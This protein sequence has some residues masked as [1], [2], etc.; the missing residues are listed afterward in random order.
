MA[1]TPQTMVL[2]SLLLSLS[3]LPIAL[4]LAEAGAESEDTAA[5]LAF[6]AAAVGSSSGTSGAV[7]A[8]WNGSGAGPCTWDGVKCSRIGRVVALRLRSLGLSGTLS[9]AVGNLSSLRELDLSSNWLRGEI[10][11]SLGRLRRLRTL[12]LS[13]NTLS[14]AVPGNLTACT[15]LRYLNLGSN[16][17]SGHVPAGLGGALARLEVLWLTNN[18][19]TGALPASL[20]N[21]TS[22]RQLGLGLNALDGPI[23]PEL[24]RNMARLEYV[25]LCHNHLRG[26]IP[27]P[28]YNVSSLA[29]LDVGQNALHG[30]IP[31]GIHVQLPRLRYLA[32]FE[33]HFSGAIPPTISNLTQLVELELSENRFSGL[34]PR[35]LG[36]LQD[37][38]KLLLDDNML[39]AGDKM[40]GWEFMESLANCSKLNLFGLGGNDFTGDLPASVA[41]LS[42]TLEWLYLE[43]L[44]ISG[45]IPSEIGNLVGLK[46]LVLTDTDISGAIPD[47]IGRMENL[48]E[49]HLDNNSLSGPVP[50][51]VGNLTKLM[52]LSAS[53]NSLGGSI[54]R[55]LGKL[56]DLT[57][58]DLSSNHLNGSIPEE[59]FQ[60]QSLSLL[61]DLS[62]N[63][64]SGP[65]PPNVGRLANLNTLRLSGNQL[66]GQLPAGIRD[67]V[68]L[69]ELLLDSNSF[70]GSI[71]EALGDIKGLRV[72]NLTM[73][74]FSGAIP[75]ALGSI[76]SMQQLYVARNSL[77]GP[78]PADLQN[79]TSLSDLDLSFND[80]QGEVPDR[81]FFRNLPRSS[82]AGNENLCGGMPRLRLHPCPTSASG[83]NSRSKRWPPLKHVE[84]ALA[85]VGA[86]VFLASLLA[87]A[88]QL[89]VC[90]SRKQR[91]QQ[92]KRQPLGA[93]A[94]TGERY[95][96]VSYK[97]LS[98][99]TKGF[100]D[101][102]LLGRGSY[103]T[104]YR[105]VLSRLTDDGGR[106]VAAS[107]AAVAVKVFD[108][109]RSG[110][111]RSFVA[112][113][114]ALRS[115]R[116]RC[117]VRTIT[118]C[119]SVDRQGQEFKALVFELMPNGNL[120][121]WLH[122]SPN[123]ADPESTLSLIQRLDIAVDVVDALDYLHNH[124]RPPIVHCDLKPSNVLLAQDM[125]A[126]VGDFG[127]SRILS[128]SDSACRAK[129]ADPNSSSVIGI[130]G[131]VGYVPPEYGEGSGVST[132]GDVYSL[133]ILLL[134]MFTGRS[135]TDDAFGDSLD[136]RGFSEAGF[137]GRIL[138]IADPNLWAHLPDT[139]TRNRVREC[140]L[141]V[142]RLAL[143][144]SKR[145][146]KDR[147]PV[148]D[149]AT[150]MRAIR[151]E[152]YLMMLAGSVVVRMEGEVVG[153]AVAPSLTSQS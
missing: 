101:A 55:N 105:C 119:S 140:L 33:N 67:C 133:G 127:L 99:G 126:R 50:S 31:A 13:V 136:L 71:P 19:V 32:L 35:D 115:A 128:D 135:P 49:L 25:D 79:L 12:D 94:A 134:E 147:T 29:S 104:V 153:G 73:N 90:R 97:E 102:N 26:E 53:G 54:P 124:C 122:P 17:L 76:R 146:P 89:V 109:E 111:T 123:E 103:G 125:S 43:N 114:E 47:S 39:E 149:A 129:A 82:V 84:M 63:S 21:L 95:E 48:V 91:R 83:K 117:L 27:A 14:G 61:L 116:H 20:A 86:V 40:E 87:A 37:L 121:R 59:T 9:P 65:L 57:S 150:E 118:C 15:S 64:L 44:A 69:E 142:I 80:L 56:T 22:L 75:D 60:L 110:S 120:S 7:L 113:C 72:L 28:L 2:L 106:T 132:L 141:A 96:R 10:P 18:S 23:P 92:T 85:T 138:E 100:S 130:R 58:L 6:K 41:K 78:I 112:E 4:A 68:V 70:Q 144:C 3:S 51:S 77:S 1:I 131:S 42:T 52:K 8:S 74:G 137:P 46:V 66:S 98:E 81:G 45:S 11:A 34:V 151:D 107:A 5:L 139:V 148:R 88:T 152:A 24:G 108:L 16:R 93:P 62:H 145:Q 143:S 30:G 36:R 38:W